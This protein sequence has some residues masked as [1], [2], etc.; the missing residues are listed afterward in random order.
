MGT[1][2]LGVPLEDFMKI[3]MPKFHHV[4][5]APKAE[6][7]DIKMYEDKDSVYS[8]P[9]DRCSTPEQCLGWIQQLN[10]KT[11]FRGEKVTEFLKAL[12]M[13]VPPS[14]WRGKI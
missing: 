7:I 4:S 13:L 10:G 14:F 8:V 5:F 3:E 1:E 6:E 2:K 11:W 9:L 12:F